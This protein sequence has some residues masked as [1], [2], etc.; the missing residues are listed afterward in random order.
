MVRASITRLAS[1]LDDLEGKTDQISTRDAAQRMSQKVKE[2]DS[3]FKTYHYG[4]IDLVDDDETL[5]KEQTVLDEHDDAIS[6]LATRIEHL[7]SACT[8]KEESAAQ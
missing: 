5:R 7:I 6:L 8:P 4:L 2:L 1:R 3:E